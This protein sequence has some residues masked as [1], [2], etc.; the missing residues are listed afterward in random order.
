MNKKCFVTYWPCGKCPSG[1][2]LDDSGNDPETGLMLLN[3]V[4]QG[5]KVGYVDANVRVGYCRCGTDN[6]S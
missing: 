2:A 5:R 1:A 6:Q 4:R 3:A